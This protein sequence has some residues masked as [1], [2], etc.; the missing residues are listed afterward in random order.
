MG[1]EEL[2]RKDAENM[3]LL[4][5]RGLTLGQNLV[6]TL[7]NPELHLRHRAPGTDQEKE[8]DEMAIELFDE[9]IGMEESWGHVARDQVMQWSRL[10][11]GG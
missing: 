3:A 5:N 10:L 9:D 6:E 8:M 4:L 1:I 11:I 7:M 2:W